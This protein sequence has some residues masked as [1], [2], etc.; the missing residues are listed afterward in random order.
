MTIP[1][2]RSSYSRAGRVALALAGGVAALTF[3][4]VSVSAVDAPAML[5]LATGPAPIKTAFEKTTSTESAPYVLTVTN[6]S[7]ET[8]KVA[9]KILLS[10]A[11]HADNKA[12]H[13]AE[14]PVPAGKSI[15]IPNLAAGDKITVSVTGYDPLEL[16][17]P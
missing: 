6:T 15:T 16:T 2:I 10:V 17:V 13:V 8:I 14:Q 5:R 1:E 7:D 3:A 12:R 11:F 4:A 9:A